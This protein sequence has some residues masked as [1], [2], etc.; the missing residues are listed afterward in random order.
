V[1]AKCHENRYVL[2]FCAG[3]EQFL[4]ERSK[5]TMHRRGAA[6]VFHGQQDFG[7]GKVPGTKRGNPDGSS[8]RFQKGLIRRGKRRGLR[9]HEGPQKPPVFRNLYGK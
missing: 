9:R 5:E 1:Y 8:Q 2:F 3:S 6:S 7:S 4:E